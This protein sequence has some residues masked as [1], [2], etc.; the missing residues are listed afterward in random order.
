LS[1]SLFFVVLPLLDEG[2][3][4]FALLVMIFVEKQ[5]GQVGWAMW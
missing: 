3:V 5:N 4:V 2:T 1:L